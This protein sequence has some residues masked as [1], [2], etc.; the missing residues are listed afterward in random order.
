MSQ[1]VSINNCRLKQKHVEL[2]SSR[3]VSRYGRA[4]AAGRQRAWA[5]TLRPLRR[6]AMRA[7]LRGKYHMVY[8]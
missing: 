2:D 5:S 7:A 4:P 1:Q 8:I 6:C 3:D